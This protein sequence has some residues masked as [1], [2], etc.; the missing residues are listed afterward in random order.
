MIK[1]SSLTG[2][3]LVRLANE[4]FPSDYGSR[5][6]QA[7]AMA[8]HIGI[9]R[10]SLL[11]FMSEE[12]RVPEQV[13]SKIIQLYGEPAPDAWRIVSIR[14]VRRDN[15]ETIQPLKPMVE[16]AWKVERYDGDWRKL[17]QLSVAEVAT[18]LQHHSM[19]DWLRHPDNDLDYDWVSQ[20]ENCE[21]LAAI[22]E[23][24]R[25]ISG[26]ALRVSCGK[27]SIAEEVRL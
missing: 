6:A 11:A 14:G 13:E 9:S 15:K 18:K 21:S 1:I 3:Y 17:A 22:D 10:R 12:R 4:H 27:L 24:A 7:E 2:E 16:Q 26:T 5:R 25:E 23:Q 19:G 8:E 20:C